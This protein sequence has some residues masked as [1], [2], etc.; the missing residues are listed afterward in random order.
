MKRENNAKMLITLSWV[1]IVGVLLCFGTSLHAQCTSPAC[2]ADT[3]GLSENC[4][5]T[6]RA[7]H[8]LTNYDPSCTYVVVLMRNGLPS[9]PI[10]TAA[11]IG[12]S[13]PYMVNIVGGGG[14]TGVL[15]I[16][17]KRPP[18]VVC[19]T[20]PIVR[21]CGY[22]PA[23]LPQ[24]TGLNDCS[25]PLN[26][27]GPIL[28]PVSAQNAC[29]N[30]LLRVNTVRWNVFDRFNNVTVCEYELQV[31]QANPA[32][33]AP[34]ADVTLECGPNLDL[35]T[36][37]LGVPTIQ[38]QPF[39][40]GG[41]CNLMMSDPSDKVVT[42]CGNSRVINRTWQF[43]NMC[44]PL[45][46]PIMIVQTITIIDTGTPSI[47]LPVSQ[48]T[49]DA[50]NNQC[51]SGII[52]LPAATI[53]EVC[54]PSQVSVFI[55]TPVG[56]V[57]GNG[58]SIAGVPVGNHVITY[59]V[60]DPCGLS[61]SATLTLIVRDNTPPN[62]ICRT[63]TTIPL[64]NF[65]TARAQASVFNNGSSDNCNP[66]FF[67][68]ARMSA[69]DC[70][71]NPQY[72]DYVDFCCSDIQDNNIVI[73]L[74]VYDVDPGPGIVN[75][76]AF[77]GRFN[78]C[79]IEVE[80]QDKL[81]PTVSCPGD[82]TVDCLTDLNFYLTNEIPEPEDNCS[83]NLTASVTLDST[84]FDVVCKKGFVIRTIS[85]SDIN[86]EIECN[87]RITLQNG[88]ISGGLVE[89]W[90]ANYMGES[91][92][93]SVDPDALP[94]GHQ[95]PVLRNFLCG[96]NLAVGW[97]DMVF[98]IVEDAC[99]KVVRTW[100]VIN[101]CTY[102]PN[103]QEGIERHVQLI[104]I[105]DD[106]EPEI[107]PL[108]DVS[109]TVSILDNN[110]SQISTLVLLPDLQAS[111]CTPENQL[112]YRYRIDLNSNG[113]YEI[114]FQNGKNA[115]RVYPIGTHTIQYLVDDM[116]GNTAAFFQTVTVNIADGKAPTPVMK[117][118]FT[119]LMPASNPPMVGINARLFNSG[120]YDNCTSQSQL[121]FAY[122][123][124]PNDTLRIFTCDHVPFDT[125]EVY[126]FDEAGN[127]DFVRV[128]INIR[129]D[130]AICPDSLGN[131][132]ITG[133]IVNEHDQSIEQVKV[134]LLG[135][136]K[137]PIVTDQSGQFNFSDLAGNR[138]Y[139]L[140]AHKNI[141]P[142]NGVSTVDILLIQ[143]HIL[144]IE[145][146][147]SPY[148]I[149]A[150]DVNKNGIISA[151]DLSDIQRLILG[152]TDEFPQSESWMFVDAQYQFPDP[153]DPL[154]FPVPDYIEIDQLRG[155]IIRNLI[156][157]K[158]GDV[159]QSAAMN[160]AQNP[161]SSGRNVKHWNI[162]AQDQKFESGE[163]IYLP[164]KSSSISDLNGFQ[165]TLQ[166]DVDKMEFLGMSKGALPEFGDHHVHHINPEEGLVS[167]NW[168]H[169]TG[170]HLQGGEEL[171]YT[172]WITKKP[173]TLSGSISIN[174]AW[175]ENEVYCLNSG[176]QKEI[177][178]V[179]EGKTTN[180]FTNSL[181]QNK[182]NPFSEET[183]IEFELAKA[184]EATISIF[185]LSGKLVWSTQG[186]F[187][188]GL[189]QVNVR[190]SNIGQDGVYLYRLDTAEFSETKRMILVSN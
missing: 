79:M 42:L 12:Q 64:N 124:N 137:A 6:I 39:I 60:S 123:A 50:L 15:L 130:E 177:R 122:S 133:K 30:P 58:G 38:G 132:I 98:Q 164:L 188:K 189:N 152:K 187:P 183:I 84:N 21:P 51:I 88:L 87:Q 18:Q 184:G 5:D 75:P 29:V 62:A 43:M 162:F 55:N 89:S 158:M 102:N 93:G 186:Q 14:C 135:S 120:S 74:R 95:R 25:P 91:C 28:I 181:K 156:G 22:D 49:V 59:I 138:F 178:L 112:V 71:P 70:D 166:Y 66:V 151:S 34:P 13:I 8:L 111:D 128:R 118:L 126:V 106:E 53:S 141:N 114:G 23:S 171:L 97:E 140:A 150:A 61:S 19:P 115:S 165:A 113:V 17:D 83:A 125:V 80:V 107:T 81:K 26:I 1:A 2:G 146:L 20:G 94:P 41:F 27:A 129:D 161:S 149:L 147:D 10:V 67:K 40:N 168:Y 167:F 36:T 119:A 175:L 160:S 154:A 52:T 153:K 172:R 45:A 157:I 47:T 3:Y 100:T 148:K 65:G 104:K 31:V 121:R 134:S 108:A 9:P 170:V 99:F 136:N 182:P 179:F 90:P 163:Y 57:N 103:T 54:S 63:F 176:L 169:A 11:D 139:K 44:D 131:G 16:E 109:V 110:C 142:R 155:A 32:D 4:N 85:Y 190:K 86:N 127:F 73:I 56:V 145:E 78:S 72:N 117:E 144:G 185:D 82:I 33:L 101:W 46:P 48:I 116:C 24:P 173:G 37:N 143:R 7:E 76:N 174:S 180:Q 77:Q 69:N 159:N 92:G 35:S 96:A 105:L 68:V